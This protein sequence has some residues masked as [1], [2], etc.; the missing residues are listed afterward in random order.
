MSGIL[1]VGAT[2]GTGFEI[3]QELLRENREVRVFA[4]NEGKA[5]EKFGEK[6]E[7]VIGDLQ[8]PDKMPEAV[9]D[10]DHII[11]TAGVTKRP[12]GEDLIVQTEFDGLKKT[13]EAAKNA[14]FAGKFLFLSSI[15]VTKENWASRLL[16]KIKGNALKWRKAMEDEIRKSGFD[17][18]IVRAGF[19]MNGAGGKK[20]LE[21]SQNEYPLYLCYRISRADVA[22]IFVE[23]LKDDNTN[24]T[25]FD[26]VWGSEKRQ[27]SESFR[28]LKKD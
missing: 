27:L 10:I 2:Q 23:A 9:K 5:R 6:V 18:T 16:N 24:R 14:G 3:V 7:I 13:L 4:R 17:Y 12:C 26:A 1:V 8:N 22:K 20:P 11:F 28:K 21:L 19:L 15:G 25:T